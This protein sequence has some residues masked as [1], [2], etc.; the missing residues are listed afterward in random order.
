MKILAIGG[1]VGHFREIKVQLEHGGLQVETAPSGSKGFQILETNPSIDL[2]ILDAASTAD[3]CGQSF[4]RAVKTSARLCRIP[5]LV[6]GRS[7]TAD[8]LTRYLQQGADDVVLLPSDEATLIAKIERAAKRGKLTVLVVDDEP[9]I[10]KILTSF[11]ELE[12]FN[13]RSANS[14]EEALALLEQERTHA[15]VA[16]IGLPRMS[17][18]ELLATIKE[19]WPEIPVI[20]ITGR[21]SRL[22]PAD[23][24]ASRADACFA[25][26]FNNTELIETLRQVLLHTHPLPQVSA[27]PPPRVRHASLPEDR[28]PVPRAAGAEA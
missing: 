9:F 11:L 8:Q 16:D 2:V 18:L 1:M 22:Q 4:L 26:P 19:R 27:F 15:V 25:K 24:I 3:G 21:A 7:F 13:P 10:V 28:R 14:A 5:I 12:R 6:A 20:I 23:A 17:G